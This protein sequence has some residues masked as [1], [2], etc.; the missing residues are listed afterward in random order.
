MIFDP[1]PL[2]LPSEYRVKFATDPW[3]RRDAAALRR[4]VFCDDGSSICHVDSKGWA[5]PFRSVLPAPTALDV[6][7][8]TG[9]TQE[10]NVT[11]SIS[12]SFR[13]M[14][15]ID[16]PDVGQSLLKRSIN[17]TYV[18]VEPFHLF[19]YVDE[20]AFRYN[21]RLPMSDADRF[22]FLV[23]K[24][25]GKRLTYATLTGKDADALHHSSAETRTEEEPF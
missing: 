16:P 11:I 7:A 13:E 5:G 23:R 15:D 19:R 6:S 12:H 14:V 20:Q 8:S 25:V 18:S 9:I 3:E 22:S 17:G 2:F 4:A 10:F 1:F 21:N 24:V